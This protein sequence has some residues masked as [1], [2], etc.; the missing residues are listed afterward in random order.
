MAGLR[1][2]S[3]SDPKVL[4]RVADFYRRAGDFGEAESALRQAL[5][6]EPKNLGSL[7]QL[8][9]VLERQKKHDAAEG[10]FREA[11]KVEPD[12]APVL[13]YLGYMNADRNVR[14][15]EAYTLIQKAVEIEPQSAAYQDSL[16]WALYRLNRLDAAE[17]AVRRALERDTANAVILDHLGDIVAKRG[18]VA[19]ALGYW[20]QAA[21]GEDDEGE[22]D[23]TR[24]EAKIREAQGALQAQQQSTR[25]P[26]PELAAAALL[27]AAACATARPP[28]PGV[29][30]KA[31]AASSWSGSLRVSVAVR[32]CA[33]ARAR[34]SPSGAPTRSGSRSPAPPV[35]G[36]SRWRRRAD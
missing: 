36:S 3:P 9:A 8:G 10:V 14:V 7:F 15:E 26:R 17:A 33:A 23:R 27:L 32:S 28:A 1:A 18:R 29:A 5:L 22:L 30:E 6:A 20:Q 19:E 12:S 4:G 31:R 21:K 34:S 2:K 16:G 35:R 25:R 24:V 13:N 11:L